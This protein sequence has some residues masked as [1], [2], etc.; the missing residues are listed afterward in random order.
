MKNNSHNNLVIKN[1]TEQFNQ[2]QKGSEYYNDM[3]NK[4]YTDEIKKQLEKDEKDFNTDLNEIKIL[5]TNY[6]TMDKYKDKLYYLL[7]KLLKEKK[8]IIDKLE[9]FISSVSTND[10]KVYYKI[11]QIDYLSKINKILL[12]LFW[13]LF[14]CYSLFVL[15]FKKK[16][17]NYKTWIIIILLSLIPSI[18]IP[19]IRIILVKIHKKFKN[20]I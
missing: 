10:R 15:L 6:E 19:F 8:L 2:N 3:L 7:E 5:N 4:K 1:T 18:I 12:I 9:K 11:Q 20:I 14:V 17:N 13:I 16:Y